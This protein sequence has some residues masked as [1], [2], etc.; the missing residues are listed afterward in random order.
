ML[1]TVNWGGSELGRELGLNATSRRK[2]E[3]RRIA[4][5]RERKKREAGM[6]NNRDDEPHAYGV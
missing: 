6:E 4:E 2:G 1:S 5:G 3:E